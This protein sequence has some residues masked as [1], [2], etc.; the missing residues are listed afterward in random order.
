MDK[1]FLK[2]RLERILAEIATPHKIVDGFKDSP[3]GIVVTLEK[4]NG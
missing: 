2:E 4:T 3:K 1:A